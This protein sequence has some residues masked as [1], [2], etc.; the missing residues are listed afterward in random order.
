MALF[1][2][3]I[4]QEIPFKSFGVFYSIEFI[5]VIHLI[6]LYRF[7]V[8]NSIIRHLHI[9]SCVHQ[10]QSSLFK[11]SESPHP[12]KLN[13]EEPK[14]RGACTRFYSKTRLLLLPPGRM[15]SPTSVAPSQVLDAAFLKE[16]N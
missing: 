16:S 10:P 1:P 3:Q 6:Q 2:W 8:Y 11:S 15:P 7:Q 9:L 4:K 5:G 13:P 14:Q 12:M